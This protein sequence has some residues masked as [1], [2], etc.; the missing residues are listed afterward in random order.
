[1]K[2]LRGVLGLAVVL[3]MSLLLVGCAGSGGELKVEDAWARPG[4]PGGNS[5]AYFVIQN[6]GAADV[7][8]SASGNVAS[9]VELH[10]S[11][12]QDGTMMM[13]Q[14]EKV[15]VPANSAV[16]FKPG[17]LHVMLISLPKELKAGD[18]FPLTLRFQNAGEIQINVPVKEQ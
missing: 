11:K 14:Q 2:R 6:G 12:M 1:M 18:S 17:G 10:I 13:E 16:E 4:I 5:A 8:L 9:A 7:L 15:D 3:L